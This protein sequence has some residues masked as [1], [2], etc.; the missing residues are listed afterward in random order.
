[1]K[2]DLHLFPHK[3][4][5]VQMLTEVHKTTRVTCCATFLQQD[6]EFWQNIWFSDEA[7]FDLNGQVNKQNDRWWAEKAPDY[8]VTN[9]AH[10]QRLTVFAALHASKGIVFCFMNRMI[11]TVKYIAALEDE[12]FPQIIV[13]GKDDDEADYDIWQ[14]DGAS[15]HISHQSMMYLEDQDWLMAIVSKNGAA[16]SKKGSLEWP[17]C[18]PDLNACDY[19]LWGYL[20]S[21]V[22]EEGAIRT[23]EELEARVIRVIQELDTKDRHKI[24]NAVLSFPKRAQRC[25]DANGGPLPVN[26]TTLIKNVNFS[27]THPV[28]IH[29][30][31]ALNY[32]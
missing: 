15:S 19:F 13:R 7:H 31:N 8:K 2:K 20:K 10:P 30:A 17:P 21:R 4:Q 32:S 29:F 23:V 12:L 14:Q 1:M 27:L 28:V 5:V 9:V 18:S 3:P 22:W 6:P 11:D 26:A 16:T 25:I 24:G